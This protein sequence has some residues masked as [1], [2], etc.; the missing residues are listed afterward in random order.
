LFSLEKRRLREDLIALFSYLKGGCSE[1]ELSLFSY[2]TCDWTRRNSLKLGQRRFRLDI[3]KYFSKR[4]VSCWNGLPRGVVESLSL[5][6]FKEHLV[7]V[8]R[9]SGKYWWKVDSWSG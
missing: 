4:V 8:L 5:E 1:E 9:F 6:A 2:I 7:A 3:G